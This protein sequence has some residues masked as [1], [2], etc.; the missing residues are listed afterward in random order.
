[1]RSRLF[2]YLFLASAAICLG[3]TGV[4]AQTSDASAE[5]IVVRP[6]FEYPIAP[7]SLTDLTARTNWLMENFWD[8]MDFKQKQ[9]VDQNALNDAFGVYTSAM[10]YADKD[11]TLHSADNLIKQ[12]K[13]NPT[14]L[15]QFTKAAEENLYGPRASV[16]IDE[17]YMRFLKATADS[18]KLPKT[19][20]LRYVDQLRRI[21]NSQQGR[22]MMT[23]KMA[24]RDGAKCTWTPTA[25]INIIEFGSPE[26]DDCRQAKN[27][28]E[29]NLRFRE[30]LNEGR[31]SMT[32]IVV[33]E[34]SDGSLMALTATYPENW[35]V[36]YN[37]DI[38]DDIDA[39]TTP[40]IFV[41][42]ADGNVLA[43]NITVNEAIYMAIKE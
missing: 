17:V 8:R 18:K 2:R 22:K 23:L 43:K 30:A 5:V 15:L 28:L 11:V 24:T 33:E 26:C 20:R 41:L 42:D 13:K 14:L 1:M 39:R 38:I 27:L 12:L 34:D 32:F 29:T 35:T 4:N 10:Q 3:M 40:S 6:L 7:E 25:P 37:P 21:S 16:W 19:R 36:G 9:S 31:I